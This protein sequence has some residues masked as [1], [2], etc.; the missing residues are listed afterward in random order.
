[1]LEME[2]LQEKSENACL[3]QKLDE[4]DEVIHQL[5]AARIESVKRI[6]SLKRRNEITENRCDFLK[7]AYD[8]ANQKNHVEVVVELNKKIEQ[9]RIDSMSMSELR[10]NIDELK[11]KNEALQLECDKMAISTIELPEWNSPEKSNEQK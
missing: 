3:T 7:N 1:M 2:F 10:K 5:S 8:F 9:L 6:E 11:S 4:S